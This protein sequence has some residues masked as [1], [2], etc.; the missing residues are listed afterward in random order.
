MKRMTPEPA[1]LGWAVPGSQR[2]LFVER[3]G[4]ASEP[5]SERAKW[6]VITL[7][8]AE[9]VLDRAFLSAGQADD[10]L[11]ELSREVDWVRDEVTVFGKRHPIPRL[12][13]WYGD[14]AA[15]YRWSGLT[16]RPRPWT[17]TLARLK[18]KVEGACEARF[19]SVLCNLY[20]DGNDTM[21][22]HA[23]DEP[24]L[25]PEPVIASLSLGATRDFVLKPRAGGERRVL[26]LAA[27]SLLIMRGSTQQH[28]VH[29]LPRRARVK[30]PR[31]NL[32]FRW[33]DVDGQ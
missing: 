24:E 12:H 11:E 22:F 2:E 23:D 32:T 26:A 19:N 5:A 30:A 27:G 9:L 15:D 31:I 7:A 10:A 21:G 20:R 4:R 16:M 29:G 1:G 17:P 33:I 8:K 3:S 14:H 28:W 13:Q 25:G 18:A 6:E